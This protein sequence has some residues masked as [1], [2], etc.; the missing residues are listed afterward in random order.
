M[1]AIEAAI[2]GSTMVAGIE[3][4]PAAASPSVY[5]WSLRSQDQSIRVNLSDADVTRQIDNA[6]EY[7]VVDL[8]DQEI[9]EYELVGERTQPAQG[10][11]RRQRSAAGH[12]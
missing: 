5:R 9:S 3:M 2:S 6:L 7:Y 10:Q 4:N 8:N 1:K 12:G 11:S